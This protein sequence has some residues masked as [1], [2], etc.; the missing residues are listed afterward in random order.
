MKKL[1]HRFSHGYDKN[2]EVL[3]QKTN[4]ANFW[5]K[6]QQKNVYFKFYTDVKNFFYSIKYTFIVK[7][8]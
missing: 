8:F 7:R 5:T 2:L 6:I 4:W 1:A 3:L